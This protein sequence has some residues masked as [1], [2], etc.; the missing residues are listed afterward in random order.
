MG[1]V[2][3]RLAE[4]LETLLKALRAYGHDEKCEWIRQAEE[5]LTEYRGAADPHWERV[6][7]NACSD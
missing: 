4:S 7:P 5:S 2:T 6:N 3:D 1:T